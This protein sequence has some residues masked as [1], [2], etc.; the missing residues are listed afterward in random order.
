[1]KQSTEV[2]GVTLLV[3]ADWRSGTAY[4]A[5]VQDD[6]TPTSAETMNA[7]DTSQCMHVDPAYSW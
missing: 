2:S 1:V 7:A 6:R 3:G 4:K 5:P